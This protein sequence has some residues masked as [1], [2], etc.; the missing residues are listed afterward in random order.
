M[1]EVEVGGNVFQY[2]VVWRQQVSAGPDG[3]W[4]S[5][6][7]GDVAVD[8]ITLITCG[9]DFDPGQRSYNERVVVRAQR[10]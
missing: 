7:D 1:I 10:I 5:I 8:S 9:G 2:S 3:D 4:N 6:L